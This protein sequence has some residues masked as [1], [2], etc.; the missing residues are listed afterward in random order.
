MAFNL[1]SISIRLVA[2]A[3]QFN[4]EMSAAQGR[5]HKFRIGAAAVT[6]AVVTTALSMTKFISSTLKAN[7][8]A[9]N[10]STQI[11]QNV[12]DIQALFHAGDMAGVSMSNMAISLRRLGR[13]A[14]DAAKG[15]ENLAK[16]FARLGIDAEKF[17]KMP[18]EDQ[19]IAMSVG[20]RSL[21]DS[22]E[23]QSVAFALLDTEGQAVLQLLEAGPEKI[24]EWTKAARDMGKA[25]KDAAMFTDILAKALTNVN[26]GAGGLFNDTVAE[27][28]KLWDGTKGHISDAW[29]AT[30]RFL[31]ETP[32]MRALAK[33]QADAAK[34]SNDAAVAEK[35]RKAVA[36]ARIS[37]EKKAA[38]LAEKVEKSR[39]VSRQINLATTFTGRSSA[40]SRNRP[41]KVESKKLD[42]MDQTLKQI[43]GAMRNTTTG[44]TVIFQG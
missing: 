13:R 3:R 12:E 39:S 27:L 14:S 29:K 9:F 15:N 30:K 44:S 8:A 2:N 22:S 41:T 26:A 4:R 34:A 18:I 38:L 35:T 20:M 25:N 19:V 40:L 1:Q 36:A 16:E 10:L 5:L 37:D 7:R 21:R 17:V 6:A 43:L 33:I 31:F 32:R 24:Q 23:R 28:G 42:S 11:Q